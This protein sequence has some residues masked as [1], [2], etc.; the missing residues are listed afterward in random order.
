MFTFWTRVETSEYARSMTTKVSLFS[1][2]SLLC[3]LSLLGCDDSECESAADC[4]DDLYCNGEEACVNGNCLSGNWVDCDDSRDCTSDSC[5]EELDRCVNTAV[6]RD[7][8]GHYGLDCVGD[9][10]DDRDE[11][12][13]PGAEEI[14]DGIDNDCDNIVAEDRDDDGHYDLLLCPDV[15]DDCDD[16]EPLSYPG[17]EEICDGIDNNCLDGT[18]DE[19]DTDGDGYIDL[20]CAGGD[21]CNDEDPTINPGASEVCNGEDDDCDDEPDEDFDCVL[22]EW[23]E[24]ETTC[25]SDGQVRCNDDCEIPSSPE[26]C[27]P[28]EETCNGRDDDC[29]GI[30]DN[31]LPCVAGEISECTTTC[32]TVGSGTCTDECEPAPPERCTVPPEICNGED[33]NCNT[34]VDEGFFCAVGEEADCQTTCETVG[35]GPCSDECTAAPPED[36]VPPAEVCNDFEDNDCDGDVDCTDEDCIMDMACGG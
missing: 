35:T 15:G 22:D 33:D 11:T 8:D 7:G 28:P 21:D 9:D 10:C 13:Y 34:L 32:D 6:D 29:D 4:A 5:D 3:A 36:C 12:V 23:Q 20:T 2:L 14:C 27:E 26:D 1:I 24:C 17:A 31:D 18:D 25:E 16:D 19:E 30:D